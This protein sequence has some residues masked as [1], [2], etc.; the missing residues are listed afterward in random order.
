MRHRR[1]GQ[2]LEGR[3]RHRRPVHEDDGEDT[4]EEAL[5]RLNVATSGSLRHEVAI[6]LRDE[7]E[8]LTWAARLN[9]LEVAVSALDANFRH[10]S[11]AAWESSRRP[12]RHR[13]DA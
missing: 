5:R 8:G 11:R 9:A 10:L 12:P 4:V 6:P 2:E 1:R 3:R 7:R 13:R